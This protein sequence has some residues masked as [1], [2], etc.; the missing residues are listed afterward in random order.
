MKN[1]TNFNASNISQL[2]QYDYE[3]IQNEKKR[4]I[5]LIEDIYAKQILEESR[6]IY[7]G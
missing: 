1:E 6:K 5:I 4:S 3:H 2:S 7:N